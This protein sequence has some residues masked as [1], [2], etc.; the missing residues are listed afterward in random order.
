MTKLVI[1][2]ARPPVKS[3]ISPKAF[4]DDKP[5]A[6]R[7]RTTIVGTTNL[8]ANEQTSKRANKRSREKEK[9]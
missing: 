7:K 4:P 5:A 6:K 8:R 2:P 9:V 1:E 3:K